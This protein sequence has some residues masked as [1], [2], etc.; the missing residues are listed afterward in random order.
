MAHSGI[1]T[2]S[3]PHLAEH[4]GNLHCE[5][6]SLGTLKKKEKKKLLQFFPMLK[7]TEALS[8]IMASLEMVK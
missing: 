3:S 2:C 4:M 8:F 5:H 1:L 6:I 7:Y